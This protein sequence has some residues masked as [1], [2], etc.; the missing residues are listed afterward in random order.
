MSDVAKIIGAAEAEKRAAEQLRAAVVEARDQGT[1]ITD[2]AAAARVS[3]QTIH[4]WLSEADNTVHGRTDDA[5][6]DAIL[7]MSTLVKLPH[8]ARQ[9]RDRAHGDQAMQ[10]RAM[11]MGRSWM[12]VEAYRALSEDERGVLTLGD[13]AENKIRGAR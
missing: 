7:L 2:I 10:V 5:M 4:R 3:R 11:Q 1:S 6:R 8:Q 9:L 13:M 12:S